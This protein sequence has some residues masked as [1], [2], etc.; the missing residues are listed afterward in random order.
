MGINVTA[1]SLFFQ[2]QGVDPAV[3]CGLRQLALQYAGKVLSSNPATSNYKEPVSAALDLD[4]CKPHPQ[5]K[6]F[7]RKPNPSKRPY[8]VVNFYVSASMGSDS[9]PGTSP[10][11]PFKTV[12]A[13]RDAIRAHYPLESR[14]SINVNLREGVYF[15][16]LELGP[17]DSGHSAQNPITY[18]NYENEKVTLSGGV[19]LKV[20]WSQSTTK[21][22]WKATVPKGMT[23]NSLYAY[24]SG[25]NNTRLIRARWPNGNPLV[26]GDGYATSK[27]SFKGSRS[28][29]EAFVSNVVVDSSVSKKTLLTG[30]SMRPLDEKFNVNISY[31]TDPRPS[32]TV[33]KAYENGTINRF[34]TTYNY[35]FWNTNVPMGLYFDS[36]A[37]KHM[38][39]H[40]ETGVLHTFHSEGWGGWQFQIAGLDRSDP[41][42]STLHFSRG[43]FQE[44][45]GAGSIG[46]RPFYVENIYEELDN[47]NEWF[48]DESTGT[49]YLYPDN[50]TNINAIHVVGAA[51]DFAL[52]II[53]SQANPV[54]DVTF[55]G[56]TFTHTATTYMSSY[57]VPSGGDWSIHRGATVFV[58]GAERVTIT[59]CTFDQTGGN[60][61]VF[62]NYVRSS[63]VSGCEFYACGDSAVALVGSTDLINGTRGSYPAY[64]TIERNH[65]HEIGVFG[66]QTSGY[67][68]GIARANVVK[69]NV[70]YNGPRAGVNFNDGFA[71]EEVLEGNLIFNMVRETSDHGSFNSWDRQPWLYSKTDQPG[72]ELALSPGTHQ[73]R[74]N[75]I[76]NTNF[77]GHSN[78][79]YCID[80]DD[81]SSQYNDT[82]NVLVYGG[83]KYRDGVNR[84]VSDNL[85]IYSLGA[86]FQVSGFSTDRFVDNTVVLNR[87]V[88]YTCVGAAIKGGVTTMNNRFFT[89]NDTSLSF[90]T[91]GCNV[92]GSTLKEWQ[93]ACH[94]DQGSTI[95]SDLTGNQILDMAS[96]MLGLG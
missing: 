58:D 74:G 31:P 32:W 87:G 16:P 42:T 36:T 83:V 8:A 17:L 12:A 89:P 35:P 26:P 18:Q 93:A 2:I 10:D 1:P 78:G 13:A 52:N 77:L 49:L 11:K 63:T 54:H 94:C 71:G 21:N 53:G 34:N 81:G 84:S 5:N 6:T 27:G 3:D 64:N 60:G 29:G 7:A 73:L 33:F 68:K 25:L 67:F 14:P 82:G 44:A 39:S 70:I 91:G 61:V 37:L 24:G 66:K 72:G 75:F 80:H 23:F 9:N 50:K 4:S 65:M 15:E 79:L 28:T 90:T 19:D 22:I 57:E 76:F 47:Q 30:G 88:A 55:R 46:S 20:A 69:E 62:S 38:W 43:G 85:V 51:S 86:A 41:H 92:K 96:K 95:S 48:L 45:R 56:L 59:E 40:P